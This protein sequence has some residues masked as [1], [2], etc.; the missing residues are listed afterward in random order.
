[1]QPAQQAPKI[2]PY[3]CHADCIKI[4]VVEKCNKVPFFGT[5]YRIFWPKIEILNNFIQIGFLGC[6]FS[7]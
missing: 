1:M 5:F 2:I 7:T 4:K 3:F 6:D